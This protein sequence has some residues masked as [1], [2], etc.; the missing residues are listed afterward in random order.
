MNGFDWAIVF[1]VILKWIF[2]GLCFLGLGIYVFISSLTD[3]E[4]EEI[5]YARNIRG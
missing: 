4:C 2:I 1:P 3:E 5:G